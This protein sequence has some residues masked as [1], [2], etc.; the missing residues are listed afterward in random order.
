MINKADSERY[1]FKIEFDHFND[2]E[3]YHGLDKLA[4]NNT[5]RTAHI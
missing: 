3:T 2:G 1:S 5:R 4:L